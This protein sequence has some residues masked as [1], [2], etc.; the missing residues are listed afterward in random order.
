M[1][2]FGSYIAPVDEKEIGSRLQALRK[3]RGI[4]QSEIAKML[5]IEQPLVSAYERGTIRMHGAIVAAFAKALRVSADEILGLA[6]ASTSD[7]LKDRR[8]LRRLERIERLPKR[9]KQTL[10]K[11]IDAYVEGSERQARAS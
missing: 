9:A 6:P 10:L 7:P 3:R 1:P 4:T 5:G 8:F 2:R 11:T